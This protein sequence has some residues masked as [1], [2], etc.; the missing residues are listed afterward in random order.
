[1]VLGEGGFSSRVVKTEEWRVGD[2][3][4]LSDGDVIPADLFILTTKDDKC[5][6]F[7]KT[8]SL[9]GETNLKPKLALKAINDT[10]YSADSSAIRGNFSISCPAPIADLYAFN[11]KVSYA[12]QLFDV[13]LKQFMHRGATLCNSGTVTGLVVHTS[14]DCKLIM[15]QGKY[16]FKQSSLYKGINA[17]MTF[18]ILMILIIAGAFASQTYTFVTE[19]QEKMDYVFTEDTPSASDQAFSA[20]FSFYLL[21][22]Q[23]VPM[24]LLIILEMAQIFVVKYIDNDSEMCYAVPQNQPGCQ[25]QSIELKTCQVQNYSLHEDLGQIDY[26]FCDKTGTLTKNELVFNKWSCSGNLN[27]DKLSKAGKEGGLF[28]DLLRC[29]VLCHDVLLIS[30]EKADGQVEQQKS[31]SSQD[32][33]C[34]IEMVESR[35]L[36]KLV[37]RDATS[38]TVEILGE[39]EIYELLKTFEFSSERKMMSVVMKRRDTGQILAYAKGASDSMATKL[40]RGGASSAADDLALADS[41][42]TEGLRTLAFGCKTVDGN[43]GD[44]DEVAVA[45]VESNLNLVGVTAVEDLLQ[46]EVDSCI[47]LF[48]M[49]GIK[50]WMLTGDK[51]E[52]A[53]EIGLRCG[54]YDRRS[55]TVLEVVESTDKDTLLN[56]LSQHSSVIDH[57]RQT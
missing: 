23:F 26:L 40:V 30:L 1:M 29:I 37:S 5:E 15:N 21:F 24:E 2:V 13:D 56:D 53:L 45:D 22:N 20:F 8:A 54:L 42:A 4:K 57:A 14:T 51:R 11:A 33:L 41:F 50:V 25:E 27:P 44:L 36:A 38:I 19:N 10:I 6:A 9:D 47:S 39:T 32:E 43:I 46:D 18:N 55:M 3:V 17:L 31:G 7:N 48:R 49:A 52:T 34:L 35:G 16:R 12:G 28:R